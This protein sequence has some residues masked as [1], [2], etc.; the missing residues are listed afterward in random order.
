MTKQ[1]TLPLN[2]KSSQSAFAIASATPLTLQQQALV[3][4]L[5]KELTAAN[6][7]LP[8]H[9][10]PFPDKL[11]KEGFQ[12]G[13]K[14]IG[15]SKEGNARNTVRQ[16]P[17]DGIFASEKSCT[18]NKLDKDAAF[19]ANRA[20]VLIHELAHYIDYKTGLTKDIS[21]H[22]SGQVSGK[23]R[24][25]DAREMVKSN[26]RER[27][28]DMTATL[29]TLANYPQQKDIIQNKMDLRRIHMND[30]EHN[31][32]SSVELAVADF[33]KNPRSNITVV[34]AAQ[35]ATRLLDQQKDSFVSELRKQHTTSVVN[36]SSLIRALGI[37]SEM[38]SLDIFMG[39]AAGFISDDISTAS[40]KKVDQ[41]A[42]EARQRLCAPEPLKP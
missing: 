15:I 20:Y 8:T 4:R 30:V 10:N 34:E 36:G 17:N 22:V 11:D 6:I 35:W 38:S 5:G 12:Q 9:F 19:E 27:L 18:N 25:E 40:L 29:Y 1:P 13:N 31:T 26:V 39:R 24:G 21:N 14:V 37:T 23:I 33:A 42:I 2:S 16:L 28:S 32:A 3:D 41:T 7:P